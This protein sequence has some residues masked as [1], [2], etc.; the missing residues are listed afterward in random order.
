VHLPASGCPA[1]GA[2]TPA[3]GTG[4]AAPGSGAVEEVVLGGA[5]S[6][7]AVVGETD[8]GASLGLV[9]SPL[10]SGSRCMVSVG[11][12]EAFGLPLSLLPASATAATAGRAITGPTVLVATPTLTLAASRV[13]NAG[14][15]TASRTLISDTAPMAR[16]TAPS[17]VT[18]SA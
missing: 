9:G 10:A 14:T 4:D 13:R 15:V 11:S 5:V 7:L 16:A 6:V 12:G 17:T 8:D 1:T 3:G 2:A 18:A